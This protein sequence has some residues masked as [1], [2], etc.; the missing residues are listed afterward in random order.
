MDTTP[1]DA[2]ADVQNADEP[3]TSHSDGLDGPSAGSRSKD[4]LKK[5]GE[6]VIED[7]N[8]K[9]AEFVKDTSIELSALIVPDTG[10][11]SVEG[12]AIKIPVPLSRRLT[13]H[14]C[15]YECAG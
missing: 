1:M 11:F 7:R 15:D 12:V 6:F 5:G 10:Q 3:T 2:Q 9:V 4:V 13:C 14:L 8:D